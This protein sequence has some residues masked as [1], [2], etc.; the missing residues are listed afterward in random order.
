M[1]HVFPRLATLDWGYITSSAARTE[2][3]A[4]RSCAEKP[5]VTL[6]ARRDVMGV[7]ACARILATRVAA[8][9]RWSI[10]ALAQGVSW[11]KS[12]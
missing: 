5:I 9:N 3:L 1:L 12:R 2:Q 10:E 6:T 8:V 11:T 7:L 4:A